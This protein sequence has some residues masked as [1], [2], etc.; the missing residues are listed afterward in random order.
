MAGGTT[1]DVLFKKMKMIE[2]DIA[3][4]FEELELVFDNVLLIGSHLNVPGFE[5]ED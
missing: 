4:V 5:I 2:N 1:N 3:K